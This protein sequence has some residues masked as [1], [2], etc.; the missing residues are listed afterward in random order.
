MKRLHIDLN[1][2]QEVTKGQSWHSLGGPSHVASRCEGPR[3]ADTHT[4]HFSERWGARLCFTRRAARCILVC[5]PREPSSK[6]A[7]SGGR[8]SSSP[9]L[10]SSLLFSAHVHCSRGAC[11]PH[12]L[13]VCV[14]H[15]LALPVREAG[16][17]VSLVSRSRRPRGVSAAYT[18]PAPMGRCSESSGKVW[19]AVGGRW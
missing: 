13:G 15:L 7:R 8:P 6:G 16:D 3:P 11:P 14:T 4:Q 18:E 1:L 17:L 5:R 9:R 10:L 19:G 12:E 2:S